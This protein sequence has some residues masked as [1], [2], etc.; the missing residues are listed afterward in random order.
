MVDHKKS[1]K[2]RTQ[3]PRRRPA[4]RA[5][6]H[7][8][9]LHTAK[10]KR[11]QKQRK[12][13]RSG[14]GSR[15][16]LVSDGLDHSRTIINNTSICDRFNMRREKVCNISGSSAFTIAQSLYLN[17]GNSALFP[18]FSQIAATYEEWKL[19]HLSFEFV[20]EA[21]TAVSSTASSGKH[22]MV[23]Q[24]DTND[25]AFTTDAQAEN[26]CGSVSFRPFGAAR[27]TVEAKKATKRGYDPLK[28]Y[29]V[30][31]AANTAYPAT[32]AAGS[33]KFYNIGLFNFIT[34]ANAVT[35]ETGELYVRYAFDMIR[36][37]QGNAP[38]NYAAMHVTSLDLAGTGV[39]GATG[40]GEWAAVPGS[41][42]TFTNSSTNFTTGG[43]L[44][45]TT[46]LISIA[47]APV[48]SC[49]VISSWT[50]SNS[51][52]TSL[53]AGT[54]SNDVTSAQYSSASSGTAV[55]TATRTFTCTSVTGLC[56]HT[57]NSL[58]IVGGGGCDIW[59][60]PLPFGVLTAKQP[61]DTRLEKLE[62][63]FSRIPAHL[64]IESDDESDEKLP[65]NR[66]AV[67]PG[68]DEEFERVGYYATN[69]VALKRRV[70]LP[71]INLPPP[72]IQGGG[73]ARMSLAPS[74]A[75]SA[76]SD[77]TK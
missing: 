53:L 48:T 35:S 75:G 67:G 32:D 40:S 13:N 3:A 17:P 56:T 54:A 15:D 55:V 68:S 42:Y 71:P 6:A 34:S 10:P 29:Y 43:L 38:P 20:T 4:R 59:L 51:S 18:I 63:F 7:K 11:K 8:P 52:N 65:P 22:I 41:S 16:R 45:G 64:L 47:I 14:A 39:P 44:N 70:R 36:P 49:T 57:I 62:R 69:E 23:T 50:I 19:R 24:F 28:T 77:S 27:H 33:T 21:Y 9:R 61:V 73:G 1:A 5:K 58:T 25:P 2:P 12:N 30:N 76:K 46:Y 74:P 72:L 66:I 31:P 37:K 26:Y 60:F